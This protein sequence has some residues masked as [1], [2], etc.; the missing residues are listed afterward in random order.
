MSHILWLIFIIL[1]G[2]ARLPPLPLRKTILVPAP[3][4]LSRL[5]DC[6]SIDYAQK[7]SAAFHSGSRGDFCLRSD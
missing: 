2:Q 4:P 5:R 7:D 6:H 1:S 3:T